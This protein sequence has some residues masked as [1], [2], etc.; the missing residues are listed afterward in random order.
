MPN[1]GA[2]VPRQPQDNENIKREKQ[3]IRR[4]SIKNIREVNQ[5]KTTLESEKDNPFVN[6][7]LRG[8]EQKHNEDDV[9]ASYDQPKIKPIDMQR[10]R[11]RHYNVFKIVMIAFACIIA[12]SLILLLIEIIKQIINY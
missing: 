6:G 3:R 7:D 12:I 10:Y 4:K 1:Y 5:L 9:F 2:Y 8:A 11:K